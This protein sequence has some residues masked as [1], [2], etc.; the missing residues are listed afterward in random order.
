LEWSLDCFICIAA[1][2]SYIAL[3][4]AEILLCVKRDGLRTILKDAQRLLNNHMYFVIQY[5]VHRGK[6][7]KLSVILSKW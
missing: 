3:T 1:C 2:Y 4:P 5:E 6:Y 7:I